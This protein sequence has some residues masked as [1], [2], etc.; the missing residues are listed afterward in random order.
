MRLTVRDVGYVKLE[1]EGK[2]RQASFC[3]VGTYESDGDDEGF[4]DGMRNRN[5]TQSIMSEH[6]ASDKLIRNKQQRHLKNIGK[7]L[8]RKT[9]TIRSRVFGFFRF[10]G[11]LERIRRL[12]H[13]KENKDEEEEKLCT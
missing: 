13:H 3:S 9:K 5:E 12:Q 4:C 1:F 6:S 7:S 8:K 11:L 2:L 10:R